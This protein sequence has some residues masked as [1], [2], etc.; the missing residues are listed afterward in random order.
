[1]VTEAKADLEN[2]D[3]EHTKA[4]EKLFQVRQGMPKN[5]Q[6]GRLLENAPIRK[7]FEKFDLE[8]AGDFNKV[9]RYKLKEE[10]Y[11]VIDEKQHQADLTEKGRKF[12]NPDDPDAFVLLDLPS[13]FV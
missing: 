3:I 13:L 8:M 4:L 2:P 11:F 1:M 6:L 10:L 9:I 7:T 5:K 12:L